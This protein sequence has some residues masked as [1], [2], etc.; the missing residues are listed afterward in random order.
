MNEFWTSVL[1]TALGG[2]VVLVLG[3]RL[4]LRRFYT[5]RWWD[6]KAEAYTDLIGALYR[7]ANAYDPEYVHPDDADQPG[8]RYRA[9]ASPKVRMQ[10][11]ATAEINRALAM[12]DFLFS[13][14]AVGVLIRMNGAILRLDLTRPQP[15]LPPNHRLRSTAAAVRDALADLKAEAARDLQFRRPFRWSRI[16]AQFGHDSDKAVRKLAERRVAAPPEEG[17]LSDPSNRDSEG[18]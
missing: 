9:G 11:E 7:L 8:I 6:R 17:V 13:P 14:A 18:I 3:V 12:G 2:S 15:P 4:A 10:R 1:S 5:E 16:F